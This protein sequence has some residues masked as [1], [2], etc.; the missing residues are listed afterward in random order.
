MCGRT[1]RQA[2]GLGL[3]L[4]VGAGAALLLSGHTPYGQWVVYRKKHLLIGCHKA[5]PGAYDLAKQ[6]VAQLD[7]HLPAAKS[8]V[9]RAPHAGRLASLLATAQMD[10][11]T[12]SG[13]EAAAM[14]AG[15]GGFAPYGPV[16]LRLLLPLGDRLL[17]ARADFPE[18]HAWLV[19]AALAGTD[20]APEIQT[21]QEAA[22]PWHPGSRAFL[23]GRPE[24]G[25]D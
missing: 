12:L 2:L 7:A 21:A 5:D 17:I 20:L 18:R 11:A 10:V 16:A 25:S 24:P 9:A 23:E 19:T 15:S 14:Q 4:G 6:V 3:R 22:V 13:S 1:R 8:R